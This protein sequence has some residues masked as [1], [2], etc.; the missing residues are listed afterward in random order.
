MEQ[1]AKCIY[2]P[3]IRPVDQAIESSAYRG[4]IINCQILQIVKCHF[5][6]IISKTWWQ[7]SK[8]GELFE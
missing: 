2:Y 1:L 4:K 6:R 3:W 7:L 8:V 5:Q